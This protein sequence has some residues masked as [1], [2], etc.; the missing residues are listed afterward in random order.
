MKDY[1]EVLE[2][3]KGASKDEVKKAFRR[4]AAKYHPDKKTGDEH[5]YK[6]IT[7]AY[8][9]LGDDKKKAEY[10]AY[11]HSFQG[12]GGGF[13]WADFSQ[14]GNAQGFSF[15]IND[16]FENFGFSGQQHSRV[17]KGTDISI[18]LDITFKESIF[19]TERKVMITKNA[20]CEYCSGSGAKK[21]TELIT[22]TTCG[23]QGKVQQASQSIFGQQFTTVRT[24]SV[25]NGIGKVPKEK[26]PH[27]TG[28][29]VCRIQEEVTI[30]IPAGIQNNEVLGMRGY[31]NAIKDGEA[32]D[33]Y[34]HIKVPEDST[35]KRVGNNLYKDIPIKITDALLGNEYTVTTLDG[36]VTIVIPPGITHGEL[37]R[38][39]ERGVPTP[40]GRG[41]FMC[42]I[43]VETPKKLSKKA[44]KLIEELRGEG[45]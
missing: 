8:A 17:K 32:G 40:S 29:G 39:K 33:L 24:C 44:T 11:G 19:G 4:L 5:K 27:C 31:G 1:Y 22:C 18:A 26:C 25:C 3:Q 20:T 6:E 42:K 34:V 43:I 28:T 35:I 7:E 45:V 14:A 23:G 37:L 12:G 13:N 36:D 30:K 2:L 10:D 41:D 15:D 38:V 21:G 9:V 16:I